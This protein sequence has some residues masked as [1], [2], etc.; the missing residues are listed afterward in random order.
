MFPELVVQCQQFYENESYENQM[1][2]EGRSY[3]GGGDHIYISAGPLFKGA[4]GCGEY[5]TYLYAKLSLH[6][7]RC[8]A[9]CLI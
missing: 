5:E 4:P 7:V 2:P 1:E 8:N 3:E 9:V 6:A